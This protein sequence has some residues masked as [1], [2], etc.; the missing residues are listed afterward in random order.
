MH[1]Y[2]NC[3]AFWY[4]SGGA[5]LV[6]N[7]LNR[8]Q[9]PFVNVHDGT[10]HAHGEIRAE[11][12]LYRANRD[13]APLVISRKAYPELVL[14]PYR[15]IDFVRY[16]HR[17]SAGACLSLRNATRNG[18]SIV[19]TTILPSPLIEQLPVVHL[20]DEQQ[21][22]CQQQER[23]P[24]N[25]LGFWVQAVFI[26][27]PAARFETP[28][29]R[30]NADVPDRLYVTENDMEQLRHLIESHRLSP[31]CAVNIEALEEELD[32][33]EVVSPD[34]IPTDVVTM[35]SRVR[36][37]DLDTGK[38]MDYRVVYPN[39]TSQGF[40]EWC[41]CSHHWEQ[42]CWAIRP[43]TQSNGGSNAACDG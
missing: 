11:Q 32:R 35:G 9:N 1:L 36:L 29:D 18:T 5:L 43:A 27:G 6:S 31:D 24:R 14:Q 20:A 33:A 19:N 8:R 38:V 15:C 40:G 4:L 7:P 16:A 2:G 42:R 10:S 30:S 37:K 21:S 17:S 39:T 3:A 41:Q 26:A 23:T 22:R 13:P 12:R 34:Q 28:E 25:I